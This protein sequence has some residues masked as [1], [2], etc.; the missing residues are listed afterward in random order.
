MARLEQSEQ[1]EMNPKF[2]SV[3]LDKDFQKQQLEEKDRSKVELFER[4]LAGELLT[5]DTIDRSVEKI[6]IMALTCEFGAALITK[7]ASARF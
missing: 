6:V 4:G 7:P 5:S 1:K 3:I 2:L